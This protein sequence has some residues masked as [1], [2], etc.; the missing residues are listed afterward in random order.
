MKTMMAPMW[1]WRIKDMQRLLD[2]AEALAGLGP[3]NLG[4]GQMKGTANQDRD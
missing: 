2:L 4:P 1:G 3:G